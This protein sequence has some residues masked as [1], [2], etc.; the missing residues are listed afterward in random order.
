MKQTPLHSGRRFSLGFLDKIGLTVIGVLRVD[1]LVTRLGAK[2][3]HVDNRRGIIRVHF[4]LVADVKRLLVN[5][6]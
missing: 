5:H 6:F 3:R 2:M 4:Q 1:Q